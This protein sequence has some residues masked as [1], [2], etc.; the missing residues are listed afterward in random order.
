MLDSAT[1]GSLTARSAKGRALNTSRPH[2][3]LRGY[4]IAIVVAL[5]V[6]YE[7]DNEDGADPAQPIVASV[8]A[9]YLRQPAA[10]RNGPT[11]RAGIRRD[12]KYHRGRRRG[13]RGCLRQ[14]C[15][16]VLPESQRLHSED[17]GPD[18]PAARPYGA[19]GLAGY[20]GAP[21]S[22]AGRFDRPHPRPSDG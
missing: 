20:S 4:G 10:E 11:V 12:H 2:R 8:L 13:A 15:R 7:R 1:D 3:D 14:R 9:S 18:Q 22:C 21:D 16:G 5:G 19:G 6:P 17:R